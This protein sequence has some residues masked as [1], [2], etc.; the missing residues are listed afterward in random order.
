MNILHM[1]K[2][3]KNEELKDGIVDKRVVIQKLSTT[4]PQFVDSFRKSQ[5]NYIFIFVDFTWRIGD[6]LI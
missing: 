5:K 3:K 4:Y 2:I 1:L 6:N